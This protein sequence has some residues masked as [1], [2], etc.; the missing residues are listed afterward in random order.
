MY[1]IY[2][3]PGQWSS[4]AGRALM[5]A[6]LS[7]AAGQDYTDV[8]LWVLEANARARRFYDKAGFRLTGRAGVLGGLRGLTQVRYRRLVT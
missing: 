3:L 2:V 4:G 5:D 7:L 6:V 1:A 8:S